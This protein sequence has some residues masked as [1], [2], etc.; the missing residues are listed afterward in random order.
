MLHHIAGETS[1]LTYNH[2][3][4]GIFHQLSDLATEIVEFIANFYPFTDKLISKH[5]HVYIFNVTYKFAAQFVA[6][7]SNAG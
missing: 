7:C 1:P 3:D 5:I 2:M 4:N 6:L